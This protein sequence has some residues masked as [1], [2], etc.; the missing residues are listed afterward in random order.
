M[1]YVLVTA[2]FPNITTEERRKIYSCLTGKSWV[3]IHELER[4]ID[5][6]W[7]GFFSD[8][9]SEASAI[10]TA[11]NDLFDLRVGTSGLKSC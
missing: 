1:P 11:I 10:R 7:Q 2:D 3:K 9:V 4:D 6:V 5:T 8:T